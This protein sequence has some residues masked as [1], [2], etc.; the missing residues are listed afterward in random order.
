[1]SVKGSA[2]NQFLGTEIEHSAEGESRVA[3]D[4]EPHLLNRRGVAHGGVVSALLDTALGAAVL[5]RQ[6]W[7]KKA[8]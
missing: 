2:F 5:A 3:L 1:M 6:K 7:E 4:L 8:A